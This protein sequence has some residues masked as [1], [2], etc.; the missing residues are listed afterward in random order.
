MRKQEITTGKEKNI[1]K[2]VELLLFEFPQ[3]LSTV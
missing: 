3:E 1:S 2:F